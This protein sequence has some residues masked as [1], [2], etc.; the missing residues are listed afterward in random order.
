[1]IN[2]LLLVYLLIYSTHFDLSSYIGCIEKKY[3]PK[4]VSKMEILL[5]SGNLSIHIGGRRSLAFISIMII[6]SI[7]RLS[8][9]GLLSLTTLT[10]ACAQK[11]KFF[12]WIRVRVRQVL[13]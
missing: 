8:E 5:Y 6:V 7:S 11:C 9:H 4:K 3:S 12:N 10:L 2:C 1:M 13:C